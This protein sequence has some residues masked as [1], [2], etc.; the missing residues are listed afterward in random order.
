MTANLV[1]LADFRPPP[2]DEQAHRGALMGEVLHAF[3]MY[4]RKLTRDELESLAVQA[5]AGALEG[6]IKPR[7]R[8]PVPTAAA[9]ACV[10]CGSMLRDRMRQLDRDEARAVQGLLDGLVPRERQ[11]CWGHLAGRPCECESG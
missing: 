9:A 5:R 1:H 3:A 4:T 2:D 6:P 10:P 7:R 8:L 11:R